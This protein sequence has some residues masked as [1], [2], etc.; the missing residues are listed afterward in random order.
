MPGPDQWRE[1][2][3]LERDELIPM[4]RV[5]KLDFLKIMRR[6][7]DRPDGKYI[8]VTAVT[9]R[10][11]ARQEHHRAGSHSRTGQARVNAGGC[12]RQPSAAPP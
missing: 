5:S 1:K 2:L 9:P 4:G 12:L 8:D 11:S 6:L 10:R 3:A 7:E